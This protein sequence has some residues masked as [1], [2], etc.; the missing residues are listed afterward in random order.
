MLKMLDFV[1]SPLTRTD[2]PRESARALA[3]SA[4]FLSASACAFLLTFSCST[5]FMTLTPSEAMAQD[6]EEA[7]NV[8][9]MP[10]PYGGT[11]MLAKK[12]YALENVNPYPKKWFNE[13]VESRVRA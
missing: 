10:V 13:K 3:R 4:V 7:R 12:I 6:E 9:I 1:S 11:K 2:A 8:I 5:L